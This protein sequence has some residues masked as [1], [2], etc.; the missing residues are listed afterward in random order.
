MRGLI[1]KKLGM[2]QV[3]DDGGIGQYLTKDK[4]KVI[5]YYATD[6]VFFGFIT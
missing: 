4:K 6:N 2:T 1:A 5:G 3:F